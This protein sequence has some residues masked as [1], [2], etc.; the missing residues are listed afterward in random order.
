M[1][2]INDLKVFANDTE[3]LSVP[4][5][6][7]PS[8][9]CGLLA[10]G[11]SAG[12]S[13]LM[14]AIHGEY[15]KVDGNIL[16][17][18]E[19]IHSRKVKRKT[20]LIQ[21][22]IHLLEKKS[23]REN[24]RIPLLKLTARQNE[25]VKQLSEMVGLADRL[26]SPVCRLG[27]SEKIIIEM[28]RAVVQLP[29]AILIDDIDIYFDTERYQSVMKM[30]RIACDGGTAILATAKSRLDGFGRYYHIEQGILRE[31]MA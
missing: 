7:I 24:L 23:V 14:R 10:G 17:K 29:F 2:K 28:I 9:T 27:Y 8:R 25:R 15:K 26:D 13:L 4:E 18:D 11:N 30:L 3:I 21:P 20:I 22:E 19:S 12:R 1:L 16:I 6:H 5:L 31:E